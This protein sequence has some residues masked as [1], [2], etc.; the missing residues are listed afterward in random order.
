MSFYNNS[1]EALAQVAQRG[2]GHLVPRDTQGQAGWGSEHL[3]ELWLS[4]FTAGESGKM[5]F[6]GPFQL[7]RFYDSKAEK[8]LDTDEK[9]EE[10]QVPTVK[11][12]I[13]L[14]LFE[15]CIWDDSSHHSRKREKARAPQPITMVGKIV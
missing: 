5:V 3:M 9:E 12:K 10:I 4:L 1:G 8:L 11:D 13:Q 6:K 7:Q 2:G 14:V 15:S